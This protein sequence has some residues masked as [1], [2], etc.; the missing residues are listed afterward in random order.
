MV[1]RTRDSVALA[2]TGDNARTHRIVHLL[3]AAPFFVACAGTCGERSH[4]FREGEVFSTLEEEV[5]QVSLRGDRASVVARRDP[6]SGRYSYF[7]SNGKQ[8]RTCGP[9]P[10]R[11]AAVR[12]ALS[13][14]AL[15]VFDPGRVERL[16]RLPAARWIELEVR[17]VGE[18]IAPFQVSLLAPPT[19]TSPD[20]VEALRR[21][22]NNGF[23]TDA[24]L[25]DLLRL[26]CD[27]VNQ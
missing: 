10:A 14:R 1:S 18:S 24:H 15:E 2:V 23:A 6:K 20:R 19:G 11:D 8:Q 21:P 22:L 13:V 27:K 9:T 26:N 25:L 17:G 5:A 16:L 4:V 7:F 3:L 12:H